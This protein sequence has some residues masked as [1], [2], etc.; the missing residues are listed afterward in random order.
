MAL[1]KR[2]VAAIKIEKDE[3]WEWKGGE[4]ERD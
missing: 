4:K 3:K 2:N 1:E